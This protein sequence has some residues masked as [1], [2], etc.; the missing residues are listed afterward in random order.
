MYQVNKIL[1]SH[2]DVISPQPSQFGNILNRHRSTFSDSVRLPGVTPK[3]LTPVVRLDFS[4]LDRGDAHNRGD[5]YDGTYRIHTKLKT[6]EL[7]CLTL[8][9]L[10]ASFGS[11]SLLV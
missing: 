11:V 8:G 10:Y 7:A 2:T 3:A 1:F 6:F 5:A 9:T 4:F